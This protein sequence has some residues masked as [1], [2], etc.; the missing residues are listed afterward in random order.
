MTQPTRAEYDQV[1]IPC[2]KPADLVMTHGK[3]CRLYDSQNRSYL[4]F[5]GG[6]AVNSLGNAPKIVR[7]ALKAQSAKLCHIS[8]VFTNDATLKLA[9]RLT[10]L[11]GFDR[12]FFTNS[13][14][15]PMRLRSSSPAE[16]L[17]TIMASRRMKSSPS[18]TVSTAA[19]FSRSVS[20][21]R[22]SILPASARVRVRLPICLS[23]TLVLLKSRF[24][25]APV[26]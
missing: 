13:A 11:T 4:D 5:G 22:I 26:P 6:I 12:V 17:L 23:M 18:R 19:R 14:P 25:T 3:K 24:L 8:N 20:A 7:K 10:S 16:R 9:K 2:Y 21:G 15:N 1:M